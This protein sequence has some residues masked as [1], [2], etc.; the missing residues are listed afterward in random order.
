MVN[1]ISIRIFE[2]LF[3]ENLNFIINSFQIKRCFFKKWRNIGEIFA[4]YWQKTAR[5]SWNS[6]P[7]A[8]LNLSSL[9]FTTLI[10][11]T[12]IVTYLLFRYVKNLGKKIAWIFLD[13]ETETDS[14]LL[15]FSWLTFSW[16]FF[17]L[18]SGTYP[19][20]D[21]F[22]CYENALIQSIYSSS[23]PCFSSPNSLQSRYVPQSLF[24]S[25]FW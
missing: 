25:Q 4:E 2:S 20:S 5:P 6:G 24:R 17:F 1:F 3:K 18:K 9:G 10:L 16:K 23:F 19:N 7:P 11:T 21:S 14:E 8:R 22:F 12:L 15:I 13:V